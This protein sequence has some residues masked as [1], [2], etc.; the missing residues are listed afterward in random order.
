MKNRDY[1]PPSLLGQGD[2]Q[3]TFKDFPFMKNL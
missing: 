2:T 1:F 3:N